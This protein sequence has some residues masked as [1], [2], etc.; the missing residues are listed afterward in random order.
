MAIEPLSSAMTYQA[1]QVQQAPAAT[2]ADVTTEG[3]NIDASTPQVDNLTLSVQKGSEQS[4]ANQ[5]ENEKK[6]QQS[7]RSEEFLRQTLKE[8]EK[9]AVNVK[10]EFGIHE[11]TNRITIKMVDKQ[12]KKVIKELPPEK[13]LDMIAKIWD[14]AGLLVDEKR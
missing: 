1:Q 8:L 5:D 13:T 3:Q 9:K 10:A 4:S 12:T 2:K 14:A 11:E 6:D 7:P